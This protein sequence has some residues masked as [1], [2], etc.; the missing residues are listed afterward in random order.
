MLERTV[1][2]YCR[3]IDKMDLGD[4]VRSVDL[5]H[6]LGLSKN[7]VAITLQKLSAAGLV[8]M[9]KYGRVRLSA[10]GAR[11]ARKMNFKHRVIETFLF[12]KLKVDKKRVHEEA[13]AMEHWISD[14]TVRRLYAFI[15][16]PKIDPHG[17]MIA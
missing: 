15:G 10:K 9:E 13:C 14:D 12:S 11:V 5:T 1:Q 6:A 7:T 8:E 16:K 2:D 3:S 4:G 17:R